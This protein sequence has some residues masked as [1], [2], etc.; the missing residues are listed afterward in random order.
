MKWVVSAEGKGLDFV[1]EVHVEGDKPRTTSA[2]SRSTY[3]SAFPSIS[4]STAAD[5][6]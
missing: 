3:A 2:T 4:S 5:F 1:L 6:V